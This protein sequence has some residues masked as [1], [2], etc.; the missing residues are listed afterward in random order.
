MKTIKLLLLVFFGLFFT[1][2]E[3]Q[4][5]MFSGTDISESHL[6]G[7]IVSIKKLN[8]GNE[9]PEEIVHALGKPSERTRQAGVEVWKYNFLVKSDKD[10]DDLKKIEQA[11]STRDE[12]RSRMSF[13]EKIRE[14]ELNDDKYNKLKNMQMDLEGKPPTQVNCLLKIGQ[15]GKLGNIRVEKIQA[16]GTEVLY[17]KGE[18]EHASV[19]GSGE[20]GHLPSLDAAPSNPK[21]GQTYL[22]TTDSHFYG[23]NGKEWRQL[24]TQP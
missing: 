22:N 15:D 19:F 12:R 2:S 3:A 20:A 16:E 4:V 10:S 7:V 13:Q 9:T 18:A 6:A 21:L 17:V 11:I 5:M 1:R 8:V 24:D 14:S 23:W